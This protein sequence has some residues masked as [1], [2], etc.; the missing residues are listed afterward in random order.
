MSAGN[1]IFVILRIASLAFIAALALSGSVRGQASVSPPQRYEGGS[2]FP[3]ATWQEIDP[4]SLG[5]SKDRLEA[6]L[7]F[8]KEAGSTSGMI[9]QHGLVVAHWGDV[10]RKSNLHSARK[11]LLSALI[12]IAVNK[13]QINLDQ[14]L[15]QLG[16]DDT[17]PS[18]TSIEKQ[19]RL[20][21]LIEARSGVYHP[22]VYETAGMLQSKPMRGS[23]APG[24]FWYYNNWDFNT[25]G[26]IYET[27][28]GIS[29]FEA[30][31][32]EIA[33]PIEMQDYRPA[34]GHYVEGGQVTRY[35]AYPIDM[36][37]RD[38]A[39]FGLLFLNQGRW[40]NRQIIPAT[41]VEESTRPY[42]DTT[43]GGYGYMWRT[44]ISATERAISEPQGSKR[45]YWAQGHLGQFAVICP[46]QDLVLVSLVDAKRTK[47]RMTQ[48]QMKQLLGLIES[49]QFV[50]H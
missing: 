23:H 30:F 45:T 9:V 43:G 37:A 1:R 17:K 15:G 24:E 34:D 19:A 47:Q 39:R 36:S 3:Q 41:W 14:T 26:T 50:D 28:V 44:E 22:T 33:T 18:L 5:W 25:L 7:S 13:G 48:Q 20:R 10:A 42:S 27:A 35:P 21:D 2:V 16:I 32:L 31:Q 40:G 6:A 8:A 12:G 29:I 49:A 11:S 38:L 46:Q 4:A